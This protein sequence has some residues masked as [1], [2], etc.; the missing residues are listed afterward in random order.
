[1]QTA[2]IVGSD[3]VI[4]QIG[5]DGN[6]VSVDR[7]HLTLTRPGRIAST[8]RVDTHTGK[9][10]QIDV[11]RAATRSVDL[12]GRRAEL[13]SLS[14]WLHSSSAVS[15]RVMVGDAGIGKTRLALELIDGMAREG[16]R[17]GFLTH[18][19]LRR[20]RGQRNLADWGWDTPV[21]AVVDY[22]SASVN[23]LHE[24][25][26]ALSDNPAWEDDEA[27]PSRPLR[28]LLIERHAERDAGWWAEVLGYGSTA[29]VVE[30]LADPTPM[31]LGSI[32]DPRDRR[33]IL[34]NTSKSLGSSVRPPA[35][36]DDPD[37]DRRLAEQTWG[38]VPLMLMMAA[39]SADDARFGSVLAMGSDKLAFAVAGTEMERILKV[40]E[41]TGVSGQLSPLVKHMIAITVLRQG[42]DA[43]AACTAI[44]QESAAL[45]YTIAGGVAA[46]RDALSAS[47][48]DSARGIATVEPDMIGEAL[49]LT[50]WPKSHPDTCQALARAY[51]DDPVAVGETVI[52]TCQDYVIRGYPHAMTWLR[53]ICTDT[54]DLIALIGL[55]QAMPFETVELRETRVGL[56]TKIVHLARTQ[57]HT[58]KE[59]AQLPTA[60]NN[61]SVSLSALG[62]GDEALAANNE[63]VELFRE[64]AANNPDAFNPDLARSLSNLSN[65]LSDHGQHDE[66]LSPIHEAV[67]LFRE[68]LAKKPDAFRP[69]LARALN[70]LSNRLSQHG[71]HDEALSAITKAVSIHRALATAHP[72]AFQS[73]LAND[74]NN[75]SYRLSQHGRHDEALS[76]ITEA[77]N[78]RRA[79]AAKHPD[80][81]QPDL[82][83][84][85]N[86]LSSRLSDRGR[87]KEALVPILEAV[88]LFRKLAIAHPVPFKP[89]LANALNNLSNRLADLGK[90]D[91]A[92]SAITE[93]VSIRRA[94]AA[95]HPDALK[96]DLAAALI[97]LSTRL[98]DHGER[99]EA[100]SA[101]NEAVQIYRAL[102]AAHPDVF[103]PDL[104]KSLNNLSDQLSDLG[105]HD[106]AL[107]A[108]NE[109]VELYRTFAAARPDAFQPDLA[110]SL[111]N[112]SNQLA[113]QGRHSEALAT[114]HESVQLFRVLAAARPDTFKPDL[115]RSLSNLSNRLSQRG[116]HDEALATILES[117]QL[118]RV[119]AA[120][121]PD[122]FEP[123]LA[124]SLNNLAYQLSQ[125]GRHDEAHAAIKSAVRTLRGPFL[126]LPSA[127]LRQMRALVVNYLTQS[128]RM[129]K[130]T[131]SVLLKPIAD[132]MDRV[133]NLSKR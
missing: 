16:W 31:I 64:L 11:I 101:I 78:I 54:D 74:L 83:Q 28:L 112:L 127:F 52:R 7:P 8:V 21:L 27:G 99:Q 47:L 29:A 25:L 56:L 87:H 72:D 41:G 126:A 26:K 81:F 133:S 46:L 111:R 92:L 19:E 66:A 98:S 5:G 9:P 100:L 49:L 97:N 60:L 34:T 77:V 23:Y 58:D 35:P 3:N 40:V 119:L 50:V 57:P 62:R 113:Q 125:Q 79:L 91:E 94:L 96:P 82:A 45:G 76:A 39:A 12:V 108:A 37:F 122:T 132:I 117:V 129:D 10:Q 84:S 67:E 30:Q 73:E 102:A 89:D 69:D 44:E 55:S 6:T 36:G 128:E 86:N 110:G 121:R 24:W 59:I 1:M 18:G 90:H 43:Q 71:R 63:A 13:E 124:G 116:R 80:A 107:V 15:V 61:L 68:A 70:N 33:A 2:S 17:A 65:L 130:A 42:L 4:V 75:L 120:A 48:P 95:A 22:A 131:D 105:R 38:G 104:A 123:D 53:Q 88:G 103:Q 109:A 14:E 106:D 115:A 118:F 93:A 114:I 20:F 51:K 85:L 32:D